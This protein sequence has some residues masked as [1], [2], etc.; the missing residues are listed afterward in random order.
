MR[1]SEREERERDDKTERM[2]ST[3]REND[4]TERMGSTTRENDKTERMGTMTASGPAALGMKQTTGL[5]LST[6]AG[7]GVL[8]NLRQDGVD[9]AAR[10]DPQ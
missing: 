6:W 10:A 4:K 1:E 7:G 2:G 5:P 3:T 8:T 9:G